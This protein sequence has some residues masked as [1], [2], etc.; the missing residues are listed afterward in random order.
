MISLGF[1]HTKN[2]LVVK[3]LFF[4]TALFFLRLADGIIAF[5]APNQIQETLGN[6]TWMGIVISFQSVIG[7]LS[8]IYLPGI[9]RNSHTKTLLYWAVIL[10][11]VT[12]FIFIGS[13]YMPY[14]LLFLVAMAL[15]GIYYEFL[16]FAQF[17]F[18]GTAVPANMRTYGWGII[19]V[20]MSIAY[21]LGPLIAAFLLARGTLVTEAVF[22]SLLIIG[23]FVTVFLKILHNPAPEKLK[24]TGALTEINHWRKL[25]KVIWPAV[26]ITSLLGFMDS[27]FWTT[28]AVW[29]EKLAET[30]PIGGFFLSFYQL[31]AIFLGFV[32]AKWGV[33]RGKKVLA[34][35]FLIIA[36]VSL[37]LF[38]ISDNIL[39]LLL[40]VLICA[41]AVGAIYPLI[42][43][44]YSD[45]ISRMGHD[46]EDMIGLS[47]STLNIAYIIWPPIAGFIASQIGERLSFSYLGL[48]VILASIGLLATTPKKL[49]LPQTEIHSWGAREI[50]RGR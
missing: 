17:Q 23:L 3:I 7:L 38:A 44:V 11:A 42:E 26:V 28:G 21:F 30:N 32:V 27:T 29:T 34:E 40:M 10:S 47:A 39:F 16:H 14:I 46:K 6:S 33:Y 50:I 36:G 31:P 4:S 2:P 19:N 48:L 49:R 37:M 15:W 22:L 41:S 45:L 9:L 43:A 1:L 5:W 25:I 12:S 35:K 8:D 18:M 20:S 24:H 13:I